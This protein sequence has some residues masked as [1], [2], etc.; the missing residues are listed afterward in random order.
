MAERRYDAAPRPPPGRGTARTRFALNRYLP[1]VRG[2]RHSADQKGG[3][4]LANWP[5]DRRPQLD[6]WIAH[7][8]GQRMNENFVGPHSEVKVKA[9]GERVLIVDWGTRRSWE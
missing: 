5:D 6:L 9:D 3:Y 8:R 4:G 1:H 7:T 2:K